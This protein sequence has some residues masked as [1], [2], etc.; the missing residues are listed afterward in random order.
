VEVREE[1][2][3]SVRRLGSTDLGQQHNE[4]EELILDFIIGEST[5]DY[6]KTTKNTISVGL[7]SLLDEFYK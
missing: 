6:T 5:K 7:Q 1:F 2:I 3:C 4:D